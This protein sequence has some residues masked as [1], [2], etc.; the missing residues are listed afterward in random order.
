MWSSKREL[1]EKFIENLSCVHQDSRTTSDD[2]QT[3]FTNCCE[4]REAQRVCRRSFNLCTH[5]CLQPYCWR[6]PFPR[7]QD[8]KNCCQVHRARYRDHFNLIVVVCPCWGE[9]PSL[10]FW[11]SQICCRAQG[12]SDMCVSVHCMVMWRFVNHCVSWIVLVSVG[13]VWQRHLHSYVTWQR[14]CWPSRSTTAS[15][16]VD[17]EIDGRRGGVQIRRRGRS[18][19][20]NTR[21]QKSSSRFLARHRLRWASLQS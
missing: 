8:R 3:L 11:D 5:G 19:G 7:F 9:S 15:H 12:H 4:T 10:R 17:L 6:G 2:H 13:R 20:S 1:K 18:S 14:L 16:T 21:L